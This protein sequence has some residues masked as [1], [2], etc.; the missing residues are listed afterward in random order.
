MT[1]RSQQSFIKPT[2][3][4]NDENF[5]ELEEETEENDDPSMVKLFP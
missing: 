5:P 3:Q 2:D 4:E 1:Y